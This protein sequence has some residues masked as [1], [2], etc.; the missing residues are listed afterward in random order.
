ML[1]LVEN[2]FYDLQNKNVKRVR[3]EVLDVPDKRA[4]EILKKGYAKKVNIIDLQPKKK[5]VEKKEEK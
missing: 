1:I 2:D 3:G 5:E 4:R